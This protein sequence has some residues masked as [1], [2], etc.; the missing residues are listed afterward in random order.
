MKENQE[1]KKS[2]EQAIMDPKKEFLKTVREEVIPIEEAAENYGLVP[3]DAAIMYKLV[4][5]YGDAIL[6]K[7][8]PREKENLLIEDM[9]TLTPLVLRNCNLDFRD[10]YRKIERVSTICA[11]SEEEFLYFL[12]K[13]YLLEKYYRYKFLST[14]GNNAIQLDERDQMREIFV[15]FM[16]PG[17][18]KYPY[19]LG[20]VV[21][22]WT[23]SLKFYLA[24]DDH[25]EINMR[26]IFI[27]DGCGCVYRVLVVDVDNVKSVNRSI[28]SV[29]MELLNRFLE[30]SVNYGFKI[31]NIVYP[32]GVLTDEA[33]L[34]KDIEATVLQMKRLP[35][36]G[37]PP[38]ANIRNCFSMPNYQNELTARIKE[39]YDQN[40]AIH[41]PEMVERLIRIFLNNYECYEPIATGPNYELTPL[42]FLNY[43]RQSHVNSRQKIK[44][45]R[46]SKY[47]KMI[48]DDEEEPSFEY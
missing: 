36:F 30:S 27:M 43:H 13:Y 23:E 6:H 20:D 22:L 38:V 12:K 45:Q 8:W 33:V 28:A 3:E 26:M 31:K 21:F 29:E 19:K 47:I 39:V 48:D 5:L 35:F 1:N 25:D 34:N 9:F 24:E 17:P 2:N 11:F 16:L 41:K 18:P 7:I 15:S 32:E 44:F 40:H 14:I 46:F 4:R 37:I 10:L 42:E